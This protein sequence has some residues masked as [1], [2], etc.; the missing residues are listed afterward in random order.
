MAESTNV[1]KFQVANDNYC[2]SIDEV[3]QIISPTE[4]NDSPNLAKSAI[5]IMQ[6][7]GKAIEIWD[8]TRLLKNKDVA[9]VERKRQFNSDIEESFSTIESQIESYVEEGN[10]TAEQAETLTSQLKDLR[11]EAV[12]GPLDADVVVDKKDVIVLTP[13]FTNDDRRIGILVDI[14]N[15]VD[16]VSSGEL[17]RSIGGRSIFGAI[18]PPEKE[19]SEGE[20]DDRDDE[21]LTVWV[22]IVSLYEEQV[23]N[24]D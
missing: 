4:I 21:E 22:D 24:S 16:T 6:Y 8:G 12:S 7:R 10:L 20:D 1:I 17:D 14:V 11:K 5:G 9:A 18:K 13:H 15:D 3:D 19:E 23:K 2:I